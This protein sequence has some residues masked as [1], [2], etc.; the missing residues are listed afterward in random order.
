[1]ANVLSDKFQVD[2]FFGHTGSRR[3]F[4]VLSNGI[5]A[6]Q[7]IYFRFIG[8]IERIVFPAISGMTACATSLVAYRADSVI[9]QGCRAFPMHDVLSM[10]RGIRRRAFPQPVGG[11]QHIFGLGIVTPQTFR[12]HLVCLCIFRQS[13]EIF[14]IRNIF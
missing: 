14:V 9:V 10:T 6:Y 12:G 11:F 13:H 3:I 2:I 1:M 7:A 4:F 8:E 5:V